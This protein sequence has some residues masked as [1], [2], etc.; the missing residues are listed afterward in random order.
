MLLGRAT[1]P[2]AH[3][4]CLQ[5]FLRFD[6]RAEASTN[7]HESTSCDHGR[8]TD[9]VNRRHNPYDFRGITMI[10]ELGK[11]SKETKGTPGGYLEFFTSPVKKE[12]H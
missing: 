4:A 1:S 2:T 10:I 5:Q 11:A 8:I 6:A 3:P 12:P 9:R 7:F